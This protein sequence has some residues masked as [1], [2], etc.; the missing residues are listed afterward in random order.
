ML[1]ATPSVRPTFPLIAETMMNSDQF[2]IPDHR[3]G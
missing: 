2:V 1:E 3:E